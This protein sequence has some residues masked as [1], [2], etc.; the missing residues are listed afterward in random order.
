MASDSPITHLSEAEAWHLLGSASVG[1]LAT[2]IDRQPDIFPVNFVVDGPAVVFRTAGGS[3]LLQLT[4]NA[5]VAFQADGWDEGTGWSVVVKGTAR[6]VEDSDGLRRAERLG[7]RSWVP[8]VKEHVIRIEAD[9]IEGRRF[10]FG[11]EPESEP[12]YTS[13]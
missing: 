7:L 13:D 5:V 11:D 1:R 8:T 9:D 6:E 3:K 2:V 10:A 4:V 12:D